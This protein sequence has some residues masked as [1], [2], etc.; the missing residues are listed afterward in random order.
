M[1][2]VNYNKGPFRSN[3]WH[4]TKKEALEMYMATHTAH[5]NDFQQVVADVAKDFNL[6]ADTPEE[7]EVVFQSLRGMRSFCEVGPPL[8]LQRWGSINEAWV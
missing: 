6:P 4:I 3:A 5:S 2:I 1:V 8:K 7:Q